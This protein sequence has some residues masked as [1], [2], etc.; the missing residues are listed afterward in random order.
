VVGWFE[1]RISLVV[2]ET[3]IERAANEHGS[4]T[5]Q[6]ISADD[7]HRAESCLCNGL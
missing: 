5:V 2:F 1:D 6:E 4:V 7:K 3:G